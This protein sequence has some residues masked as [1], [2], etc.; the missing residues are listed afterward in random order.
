MSR[1]SLREVAQSEFKVITLICRNQIATWQYGGTINIDANGTEAFRG[2]YKLPLPQGWDCNRPT[3]LAV[4][5]V[6]IYGIP[7]GQ[8]SGS[9]QIP[10]FFQVRSNALAGEAVYEAK[11]FRGPINYD[12]P[13]G[14]GV[15]NEMSTSYPYTTTENG[16]EVEVA[17]SNLLQSIPNPIV[18]SSQ[19]D[20]ATANAMANV[21]D[22]SMAGLDLD[23]YVTSVGYKI[24]WSKPVDYTSLGHKLTLNSGQTMVDLYIT[25]GGDIGNKMPPDYGGV[26][27]E[28]RLRLINYPCPPGGD[29]H[30]GPKRDTT[31]SSG[32]GWQ[33][34]LKIYQPSQP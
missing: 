15:Y 17:Q 13:I 3:Y 22:A 5:S 34:V 21:Y 29:Y 19:H 8:S 20:L 23:S 24:N 32:G 25:A 10:Y 1:T 31:G 30:V 18:Y 9:S 6:D 2:I 14:S 4:E 26:R 33:V 7:Y 11:R 12:H 16:E 28:H 27:Y